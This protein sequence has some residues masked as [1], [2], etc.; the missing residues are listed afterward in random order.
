MG[1]QAGTSTF[2]ISIIWA[3]DWQMTTVFFQLLL[4]FVVMTMNHLSQFWNVCCLEVYHA[5]DIFSICCSILGGFM[6]SFRTQRIMWATDWPVIRTT[7]RSPTPPPSTLPSLF[8]PNTL[9]THSQPQPRAAAPP[10]PQKTPTLPPH[11]PQPSL[12]TPRYKVCPPH[13]REWQRTLFPKSSTSKL[14]GKQAD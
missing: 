1:T 5:S 3:L 14:W 12:N 10:P 8:C 9:T 2:A 11:T 6:K 7:T 13:L 4:R